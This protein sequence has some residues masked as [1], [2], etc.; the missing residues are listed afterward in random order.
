MNP[1]EAG[2]SHRPA[3]RGGRARTH[4][5]VWGEEQTTPQPPKNA[6]KV[7]GRGGGGGGRKG[8]GG[9]APQTPRGVG[10]RVLSAHEPPPGGGPSHEGK[11]RPPPETVTSKLLQPVDAP[12]HRRYRQHRADQVQPT[13]PG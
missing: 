3:A 12:Q 6:A 10:Q 13:R 2:S 8:G 11:G 4:C 9:E 5:R 1:A 7:V